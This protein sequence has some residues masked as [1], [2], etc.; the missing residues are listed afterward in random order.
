MRLAPSLI[1]ILVLLI[2]HTVSAQGFS[3]TYAIPG[4]NVP[5]V[6][7]LRQDAQGRVTG[8]LS[9]QTAFQ[10]NAQVQGLMFQGYAS[11]AQGRVYI[12]GQMQGANLQLAMAEVDA[13]GQPQQQ[14]LRQMIATR[15]AGGMAASKGQGP[16]TR[17]DQGPQSGAGAG[18]T[19]PASTP[20]DRQIAQLLVRSAWCYM[21]YSQTSGTTHTERVVYRADGTGNLTGGA[22]T[23]NSGANG[24]V[25]GQSQSGTP[26]RWRLQNGVLLATQDGVQ[27]GQYPLQINTNSNGY[28][29][30][31]AAGKEYSMCN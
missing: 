16:A 8:T 31:T 3:G 22:E 4:G 5:I 9:G 19:A 15:T 1:P 2:P 28:P 11:N 6:L 14:T 7:T 18:G 27:W 24:T 29:I 25:S 10:V 26:F 23:Y 17:V 12:A 21:S 30:I 13:A 20:Q